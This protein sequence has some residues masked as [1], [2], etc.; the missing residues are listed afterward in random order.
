MM[1]IFVQSSSWRMRF[2]C[3]VISNYHVWHETFTRRRIGSDHVPNAVISLKRKLCLSSLFQPQ[4]NNTKNSVV[5]AVVNAMKESNTAS[6]TPMVPHL[7]SVFFVTH[8]L[9]WPFP[10]EH[11]QVF[12]VVFG[13]CQKFLNPFCMYWILQTYSLMCT[14]C[15][16]LFFS[17]C[18][19]WGHSCLSKHIWYT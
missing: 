11:D 15:H 5:S 10:I 4:T 12:A 16:Q 9:I 13:A 7:H 17:L 1:D 8:L 6:S 18:V 19:Y 14:R 2:I 3:C